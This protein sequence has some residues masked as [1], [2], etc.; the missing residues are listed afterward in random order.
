MN[1][2][3]C[4]LGYYPGVTGG[5]ERQARLQAEELVRRGHRVTVVCARTG[6]LPS[7]WLGGVR[8]VRLRRFDRRPLTRMSYLLRLSVWLLAHVRDHDIVHVHLA[9]LQAD[10]AVLISHLYR[11]PCYVKVACGGSVG[12]VARLAPAARF[13]RWYGLRHADRVQVLSKE[14]RGELTAIGVREARI[15]EIPNGVDLTEFRPVPAEGKRRLRAE[16]GLPESSRL[17]LFIGRLVDYKGIGDLFEAWPLVQGENRQL[18]VLGATEGQ[19]INAPAGI[20]VRG[21]ARSPLRYLQA[22]DVFVHPSHADGM[23][24]AV[25]EAMACGCALVA[26]EHGATDGFLTPD[27]DSL[28][29]PVRDPEALAAALD[30]VLANPDL[31]TQLALGARESVRRYA[32]SRIVARIVDEYGLLLAGSGAGAPSDRADHWPAVASPGVEE[33]KASR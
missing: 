28:L 14:I 20:I 11:R 31:C 22:A 21:W 33:L 17:V 19:Q 1:V 13:S 7:G 3:F 29:V 6:N 2:L 15:A 26:T 27:R 12:E 18:L 5:A 10:I 8:I 23:A 9:N 24:N 32:I 4:T 30:R 16:L 25:L